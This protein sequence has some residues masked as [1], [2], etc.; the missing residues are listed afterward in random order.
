MAYLF[1]FSGRKT[2]GDT[3]F[4]VATIL[5]CIVFLNS[6]NKLTEKTLKVLRPAQAENKK[7]RAIRLYL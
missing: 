7:S 5:H 3:T 4:R 2:S 6:T 1:L